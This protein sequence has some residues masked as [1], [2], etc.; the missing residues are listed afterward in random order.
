MA[1][2]TKLNKVQ[3]GLENPKGT[4]ANATALW[5]GS[6]K[7]N[8]DTEAVTPDENVGYLCDVDR[9]YIPFE[10]SSMEFQE[11]PASFEQ[12]PYP[13]SAGI[14]DTVSG[15]AT[16]GTSDGFIYSYPLATTAAPTT[17]AYTVEGGDNQQE[18]QCTYGYAQEIN[19]SGAPKEAVKL[20]SKWGARG[21]AKGTFTAG[22]TPPTV[23]D[24]LFQR[25]K[26]YLDAVSGT[27]GTT[28]LTNT[29][30]GWNMKILTG[31]Q[32]V[33]TGDGS[34]SFSFDKFIGAKVNGSITFE[35]D[36][37]GVARYDDFK[38]GTTK[39]V[40]MEF[41]GSALAGAGGSFT[42]KALRIDMSMKI[43]KVN[44]LDSINGN[45]TVKIDYK[46]VYNATANLFCVLTVVNK[47]A[48][49][50]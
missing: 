45:N 10:D 17:K 43:L 47:L 38:A 5:L 26:L 16:G 8:D 40:R 7:L 35:H 4:E 18:Y 14:K 13:L 3:L 21:M 37:A 23:E 11:I 28:Q 34:L 6:V 1:G 32:A 48:S 41:L 25:G 49:L 27:I 42:T 2:V 19:L 33:W 20:S 30:L 31:I 22:I 39:Q 12:L 44:L 9:S 46:A 15:T 29:W 50:I 36:A 24:I